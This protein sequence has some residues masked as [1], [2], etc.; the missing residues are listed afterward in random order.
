[1]NPIEQLLREETGHSFALIKTET[2][3][4]KTSKQTQQQ[5]Q[6]LNHTK[7]TKISKRN[8]SIGNSY[9]TAIH[10]RMIKNELN[11]ENFSA[12]PRTWATRINQG[13]IQH[14]ETKQLYVEYY[15]LSIN[16]TTSKYYWENNQ[17]LTPA[18]LNYAKE[19]LFKPISQSKKQTEAG[20]NEQQQVK[21]NIVKIENVTYMKAFGRSAWR[22]PK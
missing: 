8:V 21:V 12:Q 3:P 6:Q 11:P 5:I 17:E 7:I 22:T 10:N 4:C 18:E 15:Y 1:M 13:L 16:P 14:K 20:L 19:F 9:Q 2:N